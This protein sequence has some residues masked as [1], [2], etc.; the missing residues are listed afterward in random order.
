MKQ[1]RSARFTSYSGHL[2]PNTE[3]S[4]STPLESL[5]SQLFIFMISSY[6]LCLLCI[7]YPPNISHDFLHKCTVACVKLLNS[8]IFYNCKN[9]CCI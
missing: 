2:L 8:K 1:G 5:A 3:V 9:A 7:L 6:F 4:A